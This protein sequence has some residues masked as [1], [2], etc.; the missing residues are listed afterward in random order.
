MSE[1]QNYE[2]PLEI[3]EKELRYILPELFTPFVNER[4]WDVSIEEGV[5]GNHYKILYEMSRPVPAGFDDGELAGMQDRIGIVDEYGEIIDDYGLWTEG[6]RVWRAAEDPDLDQPTSESKR[7]FFEF[8]GF[9]TDQTMD[10]MQKLLDSLESHEPQERKGII[11]RFLGRLG[12]EKK[13]SDP[14]P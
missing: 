14:N 5:D 7:L 4:G 11:S 8:E 6:V 12:L 1:Y 10:V 13:Q 3:D 9:P 2:L